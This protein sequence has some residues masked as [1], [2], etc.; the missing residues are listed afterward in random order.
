VLA[1]TWAVL[2]L[3]RRRRDLFLS[4]LGISWFWLMGATFLAQFPAS[5]WIAVLLSGN[6]DPEAAGRSRVGHPDGAHPG[7]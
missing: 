4:V 5:R 1:E 7:G 3:I 6:G 2:G